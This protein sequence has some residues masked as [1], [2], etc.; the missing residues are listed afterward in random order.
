MPGVTGI[1]FIVAVNTG[2]SGSPVYTDVG[3][4]RNATL[5]LNLGEAI[6]TSKD[7][8][9]WEESIPTVRDWGIDFDS[10]L[11]EADAGYAELEDKYFNRTSLQVRLTTAAANTYIG[12]CNLSNLSMDTPHDSE[13]SISGSLKGTGPLVKA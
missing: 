9:N 1:S 11:L 8:S 7:S 3:G 6:T 4:Q 12:L 2:T 5:N 13:A 10:I